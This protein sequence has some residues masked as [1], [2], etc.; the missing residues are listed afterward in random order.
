M[1][2]FFRKLGIFI[3]NKRLVVIIISLMLIVASFFGAMQLTMDAGIE[4]FISTDSQVYKDHARLNQHFSSKAIVV[5][6]TGDDI[7]QLLQPENVRAMET[8]ETEMGA[9][10]RVIS[11][12]GPTFFIKQV[13]AQ[14]TGTP[15]LPDDPRALQAIVMDPQS[16]QI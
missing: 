16:G 2:R 1:E 5:V 8:V 4:T 14:Q 6:V 10:P 7:T 11:A 15:A 3:E 12:I 9:N 13:V